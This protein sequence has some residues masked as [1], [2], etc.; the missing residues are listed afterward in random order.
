MV[1]NL[2]Y[3]QHEWL[4]INKRM[5]TNKKI[6]ALMATNILTNGNELNN[7]NTNG[8]ELFVVIRLTFVAIRVY[9]ENLIRI[10]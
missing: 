7:I 10:L 1:T 5:A 2:K 4:Q 3:Y 6:N 9:V 8:N